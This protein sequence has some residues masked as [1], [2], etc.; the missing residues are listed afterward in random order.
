MSMPTPNDRHVEAL[1]RS[2][3][4]AWG[5]PRQAAHMTQLQ[6]ACVRYAHDTVRSLLLVD[7]DTTAEQIQRHFHQVL[8]DHEAA[9]ERLD[10][11]W[12]QAARDA[13]LE[14]MERG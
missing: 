1:V 14:E 2:H 5:T 3:L 4:A 13:A 12:G 9:A 7:P 8:V 11:L 6:I 10:Q